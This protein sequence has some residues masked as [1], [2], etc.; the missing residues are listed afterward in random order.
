MD[1]G[2]VSLYV[3]TGGLT[4]K[5]FYSLQELPIPEREVFS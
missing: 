5:L 4:N 3:M 2:L 1:L